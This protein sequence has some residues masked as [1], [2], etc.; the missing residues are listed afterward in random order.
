MRAG[1]ATFLAELGTPP[2]LIQA[3]GRCSSD[4]FLIY[5][6]KNPA[7]LINLITA[8][9]SF[10]LLS[11]IVFLC[12]PP[13]IAVTLFCLFFLLFSFLSPSYIFTKKKKKLF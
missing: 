8:Q 9:L 12:L 13:H 7:L 11:S 5:I 4:A 6:R 1:G 3:R 2:S 10:L